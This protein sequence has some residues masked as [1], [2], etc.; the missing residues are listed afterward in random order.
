MLRRIRI[1]HL[2]V[3][4]EAEL[5]LVPGLNVITGE[6]GAGKTMVVSGLGLLFGARADSGAV[7][8]GAR[9]AVIEGEIELAD[10]HPA[11]ERA[12]AAGADLDDHLILVRSLSDQGRSRAHVGGRSVPI[13]VLAEL[14]EHLIAVHGQADQWRLRHP[15]QHREL[16]DD[17]AASLDGGVAAE[18]I[19]TYRTAYRDW[20]SSARQL[21]ELSGDR[22]EQTR[23]AGMLRAALDEIE[24]LDP[25]PGED[26]ALAREEL[27]LGHADQLARSATTAAAALVGSDEMEAA[28]PVGQQNVIALLAESI[29][30][31]RE[32]AEHDP[33]LADLADRLDEVSHLTA[34]LAS[35]LGRYGH[36]LDLNPERLAWVQQRRADLT[37][38][39]R[40]Y[41]TDVDDVLAWAERSA[42]DLAELD[43]SSER[44]DEL[45]HQVHALD[46][47]CST[48]ASQL[49]AARAE[50]AAR[51]A[52]GVTRELSH[53]A[54]GT[55]E[56]TID[57]TTV[58]RGPTGADRVEIM[59]AANPGA[60]PRSVTKAASG[61]E[62][63]R[64]MLALELVSHSSSVDGGHDGTPPVPTF[65]FDEV[66]AGVGGAAATDLG[67]RLAR[68]A[69]HAQVIVVTHLAQVAAFADRHLVVRK[70]TDGAV[71]S[72]DV[73]VVTGADRITEVARMLSG[74]SESAAARVHAEE[75]LTSHARTRA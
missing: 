21:D 32:S 20:Q 31:V 17:Y 36:D 63:S 74:A 11:A 72:S 56:L 75:L 60:A 58:E 38:L 35:D 9:S 55:A 2:G 34:D 43:T 16:L 71:T 10:Q 24:A 45:R 53:L 48:A 28:D 70:D 40:K 27:R 25:H 64:V 4:D 26:E 52:A 61:G 5:D 7:R 69:D 50:A 46:A 44:L 41:G 22:T 19:H 42:K 51:L 30:A 18:A 65:V 3:I 66:D 6:T 59:L 73:G 57:L 14:A 49:S 8:E 33:A 12:R 68:V 15:D 39:V 13:G 29:R 37:R 67:A 54:M 1:E 47:A 23:Q 62:L